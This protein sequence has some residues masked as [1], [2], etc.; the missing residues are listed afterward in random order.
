MRHATAA[1]GKP[2]RR[3]ALVLAARIGGLAADTFDANLVRP[4]ATHAAVIAVFAV[5]ADALVVLTDL[6]TETVATEDHLFS[7]ATTRRKDAA[8]DAAAARTSI[9]FTSADEALPICTAGAPV[10]AA[11]AL[12]RPVAAVWKRATFDFDPD[13]RELR[14]HLLTG[15][16]HAL[17][18]GRIIATAVAAPA[19]VS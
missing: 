17:G 16:G 2:V 5:W 4:A 9:L 11:P 19:E 14:E 10:G 7:T 8:L 13:G 18:L 12:D 3:R 15:F 1:V 6:L